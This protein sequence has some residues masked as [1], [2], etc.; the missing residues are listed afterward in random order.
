MLHSSTPISRV[1][2]SSSS[3][4]SSALFARDIII[5]FHLPAKLQ[6]WHRS[7]LGWKLNRADKRVNAGVGW[8]V[9]AVEVGRGGG[10]QRRIGFHPLELPDRETPLEAGIFPRTIRDVYANVKETCLI[11]QVRA[12]YVQF[13]YQP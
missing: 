11:R 10:I 2:T 7:G 1:K 13:K 5:E 6:A 3:S 8:G 9:G 12:C 4:F